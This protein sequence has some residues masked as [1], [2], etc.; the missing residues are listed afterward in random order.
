SGSALQWHSQEC[1]RKIH[2]LLSDSALGSCRRPQCRCLERPGCP[3]PGTSQTLRSACCRKSL[4]FACDGQK[5]NRSGKLQL[6]Q[7]TRALK[8]NRGSAGVV[9]GSGGWVGDVLIRTI[10]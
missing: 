1:F 6:A 5:N 2:A 7:N 10:A 8:A 4:L 9:I 3:S